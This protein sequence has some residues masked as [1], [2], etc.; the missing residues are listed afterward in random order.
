MDAVID[1]IVAV[2]TGRSI[3]PDSDQIGSPCTRTG[4]W[5][6][7]P[8][9]RRPTARVVD[10]GAP[11]R[12]W[13][14]AARCRGGGGRPHPGPG[15]PRLRWRWSPWT[16]P[17]WPRWPPAPAASRSAW[18][19]STAWSTTP[20]SW[21][22]RGPLTVDGFERQ[23]AVNHL[24]HFALTG[25]L[26]P[27]LLA[28]PQPRVVTV[29]SETARFGRIDFDD[30]QGSGATGPG[31]PTPRPSWPTCS[32]PWSWTGALGRPG[33][34]CAAWR[35]TPATPPP[36]SRASPE[37]RL[38]A[39]AP[40]SGPGPTAASPRTPP[41]GPGPPC[42]R[43]PT[44]QAAGG[45]LYGPSGLL[46][47][48]AV[49]DPWP[50]AAADHETARRLW[51]ASEPSPG[52]PFA[53]DP[54]LVGERSAA[55]PGAAPSPGRR[56]R[57]AGRPHAPTSPGPR[58]GASPRSGARRPQRRTATASPRGAPTSWPGE[59]PAP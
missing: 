30:L 11:M 8:G 54:R 23:L 15:A 2:P 43:P 17:T 50:A 36:A 16:W 12:S 18:A 9:R 26:L 29:T 46:G 27:C 41:P 53:S 51:E 52:S 37:R 44:R 48:P 31:G 34:P 33:R 45:T 28:A 3:D 22:C 47:G 21:A 49:L 7:S 59:R 20:A 58:S 55:S 56:P 35:L 40:A 4:G 13:P 38:G 57:A 19:A 14:A 5:R 6:P 42:G 39:P 24:G 25:R 1:A 10:A 32:S